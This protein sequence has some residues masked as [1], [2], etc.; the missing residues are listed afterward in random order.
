MKKNQKRDFIHSSGQY[1]TIRM[2]QVLQF[3]DFKLLI[4]IFAM[5]VFGF[6]MIF[7]ASATV[8]TKDLL[9]GPFNVLSSQLKSA[10]IGLVL[11]IVILFIPTNIIKDYNLIV[12][13]NLLL[14]FLLILTYFKGYI[15]GGA[16]AWLNIFG[17]SLQ[18]SEFVKVASI[19][20][21][22]WCLVHFEREYLV[23]KEQNAKQKSWLIM[24]IL[25]VNLVFIALQPD[26]GMVI[27]I[28]AVSIIQMG[29]SRLSGK[30]NIGLI[31]LAV[32]L[33]LLLVLYSSI[34]ASSG[35]PTDN[36][37]LARIISF[38]NPFMYSQSDGYQVVNGL[39]AISNGGLFGVGLGRSQMKHS[40]LPAA[41]ND[42]IIPIIGEELGLV[43][44]FAVLVCF[45]LLIYVLLQYVREV[46]DSFSRKVMIG[47]MA[48]V[49]IQMFINIG[50][51]LSIIP[52]TGVTLP[53]ISSGGT[54]L[55]SFMVLFA[56]VFNLLITD[57][58]NRQ[59]IKEHPQPH[60]ITSE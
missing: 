42:F 2:Q 55:I 32:A 18:V 19:I 21:V 34:R 59:K 48:L 43:G 25:A 36:Y 28:V 37:R 11:A 24:G 58:A 15:G 7:S 57:R 54:S 38:T 44:I 30:G 5:I 49:F 22:S 27:I 9:G 16:Q 53:F 33:Y 31:G 45:F 8:Y 50:G 40:Y 47:A 56:M 3:I 41:H 1:F 35:D 14:S 29:I 26:I 51:A 46:S 13:G 60:L 23:A 20:S 10:G 6:I 17:Y 4:L 39:L 52:L 12:F